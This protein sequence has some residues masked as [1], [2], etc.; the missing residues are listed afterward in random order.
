MGYILIQRSDD[1]LLGRVVSELDRTYETLIVADDDMSSA[2]D[3][4]EHQID[5]F[6][7]FNLTDAVIRTSELLTN[8]RFNAPTTP[9]AYVG[10]I[11]SEDY[12]PYSVTQFDAGSIC[13]LVEYLNQPRRIDI[14]VV[15]DDDAIRDVLQLSLS[16]HFEVE[17]A[18]DGPRAVQVLDKSVFDIV[19]LDVM[20]PGGIS[21]EEM[22]MHVKKTQPNAVV[23]IITAHDTRKLELEFAF[24]GADAYV[25]KPFDSNASFRRLLIK[26]LKERHEKTVQR[27]RMGTKDGTNEAWQVYAKL[28]SDYI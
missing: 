22:F 25:P 19:V 3:E 17:C 16:K 15:E 18:E 1:E 12:L 10:E 6:V 9:I 7:V 26:T 21:G 24:R 11:D 5:G 28:M 20:L 2:I 27:S 4:H 8:E 14:L 13:T 23:V